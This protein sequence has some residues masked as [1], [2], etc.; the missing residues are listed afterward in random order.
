MIFVAART[1]VVE[2]FNRG[3]LAASREVQLHHGLGGKRDGAFALNEDAF[4]AKR[5]AQ[6]QRGLHRTGCVRGPIADL[7]GA[8][9][10]EAA[11]VIGSVVTAEGPLRC[12]P[13]PQIEID[14]AGYIFAWGKILQASGMRAG[15]D[16]DVGFSDIANFAGPDDFGGGAVGFVRETLVPH[17]RGDLV[18]SGGVQQQPGF[19]GGAGQGLFAVD[20]LAALHAGE[21]HGGV[22]VVGNADGDRVDILEF[23]V[24][25]DA[26][27]FV[28]GNVRIFGEVCACA[29]FVDVAHGDDG[30]GLR[31]IVKV[32]ASLA[33]ATDGGNVQFVVV[34]LVAKGAQRGDRSETGRG[35]GASE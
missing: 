1:V 17:L 20:V 26:E 23:L 3:H 6:H 35:H 14:R 32:N 30:F 31:G 34:R 28:L 8:E 21:G 22:H 29:V 19:P 27:I 10:Q 15:R 18:F 33:A 11:P 13:K 12:A 7:T 25:H 24:K 2:N 4:Q 9:F 5:S 16:G